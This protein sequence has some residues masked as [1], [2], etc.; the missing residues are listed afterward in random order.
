M[1]DK[2]MSE[3]QNKIANKIYKDSAEKGPSGV[4]HWDDLEGKPFGETVENVKITY[5]GDTTG[6]ES[7]P[8]EGMGSY[9]KISDIVPRKEELMGGT[10]FIPDMSDRINIDKITVENLIDFTGGYCIGTE[11]CVVINEYN[12]SD[13]YG[14]KFTSNGV[15]IP[16]ADKEP[17]QSCELKYTSETIKTIDPKYL[18][19]GGGAFVVNFH[20]TQNEDGDYIITPNKS[21]SEINQALKN[22][23]LIATFTQDGGGSYGANNTLLSPMYGVA[24][25]EITENGETFVV[26]GVF[27]GDYG[28]AVADNFTIQWR[29]L[30]DFDNF[31]IVGF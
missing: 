4:K 6:L 25:N 27:Y 11:M 9:Y 8:C 17:I 14:C 13:F 3:L 10:F 31:E 23:N 7:V 26:G 2:P 22:R 5:D 1:H 18:P 19:S 29:S 30:E 21:G 20:I 15:W 28:S 12:S 24:I 16:I